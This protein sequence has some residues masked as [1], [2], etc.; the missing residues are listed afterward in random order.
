MQVPRV[1]RV[2]GSLFFTRNSEK[3]T[4]VRGKGVLSFRVRGLGGEHYFRDDA[5]SY[6]RKLGELK[7][8]LGIIYTGETYSI[9]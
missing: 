9:S 6:V 5:F 1:P 3:H 7:R 4:P 8:G 2:K